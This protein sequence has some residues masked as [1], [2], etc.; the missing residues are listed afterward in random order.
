M[1]IKPN[2]VSIIFVFE[3]KPLNEGGKKRGWE[4]GLWFP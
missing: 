2:N 1:F 3:T 4:F